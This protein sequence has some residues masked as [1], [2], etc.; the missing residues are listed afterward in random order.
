LLKEK[1]EGRK[2]VTGET[3]VPPPHA[4]CG[5]PVNLLRGNV[6]WKAE[7]Q[8]QS[9]ERQSGLEREMGASLRLIMI[10]ALTL[11]KTV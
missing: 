11:H 10:K 5:T 7:C 8:V 3:I 1:R 2:R 4:R 6:E 9:L